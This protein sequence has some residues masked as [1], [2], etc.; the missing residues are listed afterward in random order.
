MNVLKKYTIP[1]KGLGIGHHTFAFDVTDR[2]F[3]AFEGS[4][5]KKGHATVKVELDKQARGMTLGF[6]IDGEA[7]VE[8]DRCLDEFMIPVS[9]RGTLQVR[10]SETEKE[11]DGE[12]MWIS[13][14]ETELELGQYIYESIELSLSYVRVHPD[15]ADGASGCNPE[16]LARFRTVSEEEFE[17]MA[18]ERSATNVQDDPWQ[19]L[20]GLKETLENEK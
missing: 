8:C 1:Y 9:Y 7:E 6:E 19:K 2:F 10:F 4:E 16:M 15:N 18:Q 12:I 11:G 5:I 14:N 13:P 20:K 17:A 3:G